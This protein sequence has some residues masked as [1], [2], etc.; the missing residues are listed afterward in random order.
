MSRPP[1]MSPLAKNEPKE[2]TSKDTLPRNQILLL[3]VNPIKPIAEQSKKPLPRIIAQ[4]QPFGETN[5][6]RGAFVT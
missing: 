3:P 4:Q 6:F 2:R 5:H 1:K